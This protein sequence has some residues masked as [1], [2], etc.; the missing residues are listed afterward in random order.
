MSPD[1]LLTAI[2][3]FS[4]LSTFVKK[5]LCLQSILAEKLQKQKKTRVTVIDSLLCLRLI[6]A[7]PSKS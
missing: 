7:F 6:L 2:Y 4:K 1:D 5:K 3:K